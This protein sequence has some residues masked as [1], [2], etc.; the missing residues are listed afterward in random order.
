VSY[1]NYADM[2]RAQGT[3]GPADIEKIQDQIIESV[4]DRIEQM[5]DFN[6]KSAYDMGAREYKSAVVKLVKGMRR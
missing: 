5:P 3:L 2:L 6:Q 1:S 4:L